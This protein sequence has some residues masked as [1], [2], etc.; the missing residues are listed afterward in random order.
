MPLG[1]MSES[2]TDIVGKMSGNP[3]A[4]KTPRATQSAS[5]VKCALQ[6]TS[7]DAELAMPTTGRPS[8]MRVVAVGNPDDPSSHFATVCK[9]G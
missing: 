6:G 7:C 3:P 8:N 2:P 1:R 9:P 4:I 5:S